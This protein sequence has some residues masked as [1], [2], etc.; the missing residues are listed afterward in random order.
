VRDK[1][2]TARC[3]CDNLQ[4]V[5]TVNSQV[6]SFQNQSSQSQSEPTLSDNSLGTCRHSATGSGQDIYDDRVR[7]GRWVRAEGPKPSL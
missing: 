1:S 2:I 5:L 3:I 4:G 6:P 7:A